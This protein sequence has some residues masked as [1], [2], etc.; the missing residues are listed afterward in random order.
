MK[1]SWVL[2]LCLIFTGCASLAEM[3]AHILD[4]SA[5]VEKT[6]AIYKTQKKK[7]DIISVKKMKDGGEKLVLTLNALPGLTFGMTAPD[8]DGKISFTAFTFL[9]SNSSGWN[10]FTMDV[11]GSGVFRIAGSDA[12]FQLTAPLDVLQIS[13]GNIRRGDSRI[14]GDTALSAL[15]NRRERLV[16]LA[17]WMRSREGAPDFATQKAFEKYWKPILM[18]E[19]VSKKKH[20]SEWQTTDATWKR[21]E[22]VKWNTAYTAAVFPEDLGVLRDT[23]A[24]LRDWDEAVAW[25]Y[26]EAQWDTVVRSLSHGLKLAQT[27]PPMRKS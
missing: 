26:L 18:P 7:G 24:L 1:K 21:A 4:G 16:A 10:E 14:T 15:R 27:K 20:P 22:E 19:L 12:F 25:L 5:F 11:S 13:D 9:C 23:G 6:V 17:D 8:E 3:T 2:T